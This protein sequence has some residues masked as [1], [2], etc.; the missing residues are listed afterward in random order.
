MNA[1]F[2]GVLITIVI[3]ALGYDTG[4]YVYFTPYENHELTL[5]FPRCFNCPRDFG[6][7]LVALM[8]GWGGQLFRENHA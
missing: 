7:R 8:A 6:P 4:G 1:F 3:L 2:V 5:S